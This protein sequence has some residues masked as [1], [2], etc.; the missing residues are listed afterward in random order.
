MLPATII[1]RT[2]VVLALLL[3]TSSLG[4][5][6]QTHTSGTAGVPPLR[7]GV[8]IWHEAEGRCS[9]NLLYPFSTALD[10]NSGDSQQQDAAAASAAA[11]IAV[12]GVS[13]TAR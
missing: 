10:K 4:V 3:A 8:C 6:A 9:W 12:A 5:L 1:L 11:E 13:A 7:R 2:Q